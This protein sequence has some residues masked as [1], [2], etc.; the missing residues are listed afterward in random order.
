[1]GYSGCH[2]DSVIPSDTM[3]NIAFGDTVFIQLSG[4]N[5]GN[6]N[7]ITNNITTTDDDACLFSAIK[8]IST[9]RTFGMFPNPFSDQ[10]KIKTNGKAI[11]SLTSIVG[12][13][14][15]EKYYAGQNADINTSALPA[16]IYLITVTDEAGT[17]SLPGILCR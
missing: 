2:E 6:L 12:E 14:V 9:S 1:L 8:P 7:L 4:I 5:Y 10:V 16:G 13:C 15:F 17:H 3:I 11:I